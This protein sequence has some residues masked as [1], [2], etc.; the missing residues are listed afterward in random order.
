MDGIKE[1][2]LYGAQDARNPYAPVYFIHTEDDGCNKHARGTIYQLQSRKPQRTI[3][4]P[5]QAP[6]S[7]LDGALARGTQGVHG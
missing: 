5:L 3:L 2:W 6:S 1:Q 4:L 7:R